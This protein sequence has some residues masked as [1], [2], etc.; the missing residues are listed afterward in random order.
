MCIRDSLIAHLAALLINLADLRRCGFDLR[1]IF[2][3]QITHDVV[4]IAQLGQ[5][6][7]GIELRHDLVGNFLLRPQLAFLFIER[8]NRR[9]LEMC[10]RDRSSVSSI[11]KPS[12]GHIKRHPPN[13]RYAVSTG[14]E[15]P[16]RFKISRISAS[17]CSRTMNVPALPAIFACLSSFFSSKSA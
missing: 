15:K 7:G 16:L 11:S 2:Q 13:S 3:Q 17:S 10:I 9:K 6:A 4:D 8:F 14:W 12:D 1:R 5:P